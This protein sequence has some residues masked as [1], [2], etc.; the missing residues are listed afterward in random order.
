MIIININIILP[1]INSS[2]IVYVYM[3]KIKSNNNKYNNL[4]YFT[5]ITTTKIIITHT[6][7]G[8]K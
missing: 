7:A 2:G 5:I 8:I 1:Y 6:A 3:Y 4:N